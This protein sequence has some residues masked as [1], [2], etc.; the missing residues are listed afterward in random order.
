MVKNQSAQI[1]QIIGHAIQYD[2]GS[3]LKYKFLSFE[4]WVSRSNATIPLG[5]KKKTP[6][7]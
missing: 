2:I 7:V 6:A 3:F 5:E 1:G 4:E